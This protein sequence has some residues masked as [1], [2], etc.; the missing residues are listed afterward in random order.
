MSEESP[1][2][3]EQSASPS[4]RDPVISPDNIFVWFYIF[5]GQQSIY[6]FLS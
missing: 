2:R 6:T 4:L 5:K 3:E 1:G